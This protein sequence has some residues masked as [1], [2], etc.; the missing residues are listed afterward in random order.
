MGTLSVSFG[1]PIRIEIR[2]RCPPET[3]Q[4]YNSTGCTACAR[5]TTVQG[6]VACSYMRRWDS[7]DSSNVSE[8]GKLGRCCLCHSR[9]MAQ[10]RSTSTANADAPYKITMYTSC[11]RKLGGSSAVPRIQR[12]NAD[13]GEI[14]RYS[15]NSPC[16]PT[17]R[18]AFA[19]ASTALLSAYQRRDLGSRSGTAPA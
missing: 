10:A 2:P 3:V 1:C 15:R 18:V 13:A 19:A 14:I 4:Q 8:T 7:D 11:L 16:T 17:P 5:G 9:E 6:V 12:V